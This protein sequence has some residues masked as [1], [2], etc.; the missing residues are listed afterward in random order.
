MNDK[1]LDAPFEESLKFRFEDYLEEGENILWAKHPKL[2]LPFTY[3]FGIGVFFLCACILLN[4]GLQAIMGLRGHMICISVILIF[5]ILFTIRKNL[6]KKS[7]IYAVTEKRVFFQFKRPLKNKIHF[8][9]YTQINDVIVIENN[10]YK[11]FGKNYGTIYLSVK[12]PAAI[13]FTTY[14]FEVHERRHQPTIELVE[15]PEE[16]AKLIRKGILNKM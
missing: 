3:G 12:N 14:N 4:E 8:I 6:K 11:M 9:P 5:H 15:Q 13:P 7:T 10:M 16:I 2:N 1:I